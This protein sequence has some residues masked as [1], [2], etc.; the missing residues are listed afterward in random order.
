MVTD[1][2]SLPPTEVEQLVTYPIERAMLGL[3]NKEEVRSLS[4]LGLSMVTVVFDDSVPMYFA[5]QLGQR[6]AAADFFAAAARD[7]ADAGL[8]RHGFRR[9]LPVHAFRSD[10]PDGAEGSARMGD[11]A[12]TAHASRRQRNQRL[13]RPDQ[14]VS[15]R[16]RSGAARAVRADAARRRRAR[17][18]QQYQFRR[19]LHR[20]RRPNNTRCSAR[21]AP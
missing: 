2:P 20:A 6:A 8:A 13:G 18:G 1:A 14:A 12:A 17:R 5:R 10:E 7:S 16:R 11:Q 21:D 9:A 15:D 19:R 3:P 4:K